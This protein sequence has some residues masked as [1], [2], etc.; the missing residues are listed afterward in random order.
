MDYAKSFENVR[1]KDLF[2]L[3]GKL[4]FVGKYIRIMQKIS[5]EPAAC[6]GIKY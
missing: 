2:K 1:H 4:D 3:Q 5:L 6:I